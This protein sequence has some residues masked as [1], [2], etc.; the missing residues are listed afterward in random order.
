VHKPGE[1]K[2]SKDWSKLDWEKEFERQQLGDAWKLSDFNNDYGYCDT[3]PEK[4][5]FPTS[6]TKQ[7]LI[8][9]AKFRSRARLPVLTY[10]HKASGAAICR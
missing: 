5:W 3:Y 9:S 1:I 10:F 6:A 4:L 7:I 2:S 8:G